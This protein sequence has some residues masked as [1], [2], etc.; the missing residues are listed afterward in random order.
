[1]EKYHD[2]KD[3]NSSYERPLFFLRPSSVKLKKSG[4]MAARN[5]GTR[6]A[7]GLGKTT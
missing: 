3:I 4:T 7:K 2:Y 5:L 1:M 6:R